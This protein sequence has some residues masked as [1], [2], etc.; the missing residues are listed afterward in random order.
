LSV[1]ETG[2][3]VREYLDALL[4]GGDFAAYLADDVVW[5]TMETGEEVRGRDAV[6]DFIVA[7][8]TQLFDA[9]PELGNLTVAEGTA[10]LEAVFVGRHIAEFAGVPAT[11]ATV[12]VPYAVAYDVSGDRIDALR[13]Y[14]PILALV[15]QVK[16]AA[17][18]RA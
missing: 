13:G 1:E 3:T 14:F 17:G 2:R 9:S 7:L 6:R 8:H 15:E 4:T 16:A 12:R 18:G 10:V 11:G 5:T